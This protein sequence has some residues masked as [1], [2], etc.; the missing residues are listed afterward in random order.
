MADLSPP[1]HV[2]LINPTGYLYLSTKYQLGSFLGIDT[3]KIKGTMA[4]EIYINTN[5]VVCQS[6]PLLLGRADGYI[7]TNTVSQLLAQTL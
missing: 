2:S 4:N 3:A 1:S 7:F 5:N 6:W